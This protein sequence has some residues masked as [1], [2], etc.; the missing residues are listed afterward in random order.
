MELLDK[1]D[2]LEAEKKNLEQEG[3]QG[4]EALNK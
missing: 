4:V 3:E 2:A 1:C